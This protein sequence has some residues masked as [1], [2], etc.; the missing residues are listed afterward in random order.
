MLF[1]SSNHQEEEQN[2]FSQN[3]S[4]DACKVDAYGRKIS[5]FALN[6]NRVAMENPKSSFSLTRQLS[7]VTAL[8]FLNLCKSFM[9]KNNIRWQVVADSIQK[10]YC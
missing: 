3:E 5:V 7:V 2:L 1:S 8:S 4:D 10:I 6:H 9:N